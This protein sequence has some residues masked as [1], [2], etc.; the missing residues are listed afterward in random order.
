MVFEVSLPVPWDMEEVGLCA[1]LRFG[2]PE[3][4]ETVL[5]R[6]G[7]FGATVAVEGC[8]NECGWCLTPKLRL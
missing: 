5:R 1:L 7:R 3:L 8:L 6:R 2:G 4:L